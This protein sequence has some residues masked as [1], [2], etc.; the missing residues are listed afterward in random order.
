M[1]RDFSEEHFFV[2]LSGWIDG[3][4]RK[5]ASEEVDSLSNQLF[6]L[7]YKNYVIFDRVIDL[8]LNAASIRFKRP[9]KLREVT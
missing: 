8:N 5:R 4:A 2:V 1:L 9:I 6:L 7:A 3:L